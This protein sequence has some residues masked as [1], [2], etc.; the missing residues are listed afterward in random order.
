MEEIWKP[1]PGFEKLYLVSNTGRIKAN[2]KAV[3]TS[4]NGTIYVAQRKER[5]L[6]FTID[7]YGYYKVVLQE[8]KRKKFTTV[9][10]VVGAAF[11]SNPQNLPQINHKDGNKLNNNVDNLEWCTS[12][13][14]VVH[15]YKTGLSKN[16]QKGENHH[17]TNLTN[18]LVIKI[19][20]EMKEGKRNK[21][22]EKE[23]NLS[24]SAVSRIRNNQSFKDIT[25]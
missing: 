2:A 15:A 20:Q 19:R 5:E 13:Q 10:R 25:D 6:S 3:S 8:N 16:V 11:I 12:Q 24:R 14:N 1:V 21:D 9:H 23:Y 22:I 17:L 4:R 7:R 18:D